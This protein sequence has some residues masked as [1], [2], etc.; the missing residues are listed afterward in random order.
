MILFA[1]IYLYLVDIV[2]S[3]EIMKIYISQTYGYI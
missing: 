1:L 2:F 3:F